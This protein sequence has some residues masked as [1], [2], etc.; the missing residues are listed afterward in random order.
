MNRALLDQLQQMRSWPSLT[1]VFNTTRGA[2]ITDSER[3]TGHRLIQEASDR[4]GSPDGD[5]NDELRDRLIAELHQLLGSQTEVR[6]GHAIA[7]C[8]SPEYAAAV[9]LGGRVEERVV[10]DETFATRDLVADLNRT[11]SYRVTTVSESTIRTFV[12]DRTRLAEERG[13]AWPVVRAEESND[14]VWSRQVSDQLRSLD[15]AFPLPTVLVGVKRTLARV[16]EDSDVTM[17]G[18]VTGNHDR[19]GAAELH[20]LVWPVVLDWIGQREQRALDRLDDARSGRRYASGVD[21]IWPLATDK[22]IELLVVESGYTLSAHIGDNGQLDRSPN[23]DGRVTDDV[24][25]E[26]I[27]AVLQ[28]GGKITMVADGTLDDH[29]RVAAVLRF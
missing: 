27:E 7:L 24:I 11:A 22:R 19:T 4:L 6:S 8:A 23:A 26:A 5:V 16:V 2:I 3:A 12:G 21:E 17:I 10:I 20:T 18:E 9:A 29:G 15:A 1:V 14:T 28:S 13:D 25:D